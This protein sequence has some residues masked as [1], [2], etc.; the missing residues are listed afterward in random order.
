MCLTAATLIRRVLSLPATWASFDW[1]SLIVMF[2]GEVNP[3]A[4]SS[5]NRT[6]AVGCIYRQFLTNMAFVGYPPLGGPLLFLH[7]LLLWFT[8]METLAVLLAQNGYQMQTT[9]MGES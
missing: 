8:S 7:L 4:P 5:V 9:G 2:G 3:H 6:A 1:N